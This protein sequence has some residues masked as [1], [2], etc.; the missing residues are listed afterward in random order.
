MLSL[1]VSRLTECIIS[2]LYMTDSKFNR[3][4]GTMKRT[5]LTLSIVALIACSASAA[6]YYWNGSSW[7]G[8]TGGTDVD[9]IAN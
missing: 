7:N 9:T 2:F 6:D 8:G 3:K 5:L 4:D 1:S